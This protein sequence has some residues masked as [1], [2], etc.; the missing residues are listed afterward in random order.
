MLTVDYYIRYVRVVTNSQ[1]KQFLSHRPIPLLR[2]NI[3][4]KTYYIVLWSG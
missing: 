1:N 3:K 2:L 4:L